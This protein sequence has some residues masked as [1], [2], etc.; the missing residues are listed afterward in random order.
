[1][2]WIYLSPHFDDIA[3]SCGGLVWEQ[4]QSGEMV[5]IWTIC[6]GSPATQPLSGF[7]KSLHSRWE[8]DEGAMT[9]RREEDKRAN[10]RL[11]AVTTHLSILDAIYRHSAIDGTPL[12][13]SDAELFG[14]FRAEDSGLVVEL[15]ADLRKSLPEDCELV[16]P[17]ALG[18]HVDHQLVK[19]AAQSLDQRTW[20]YADFPY[21]L[22]F[23]GAKEGFATGMKQ[24]IFPV[25]EAGLKIWGE[26]AAEHRS[27][28][29]TFWSDIIEMQ[30]A[31]HQHWAK[32]NGVILWRQT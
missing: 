11:G 5:S 3:L 18:G 24:K 13:T 20:Y 30:K 25:S 8:A 15:H 31:I 1:M 21:V 9:V 10:Q 14:E 27:Q 12:Y 4:T 22:Q 6:A 17:L 29:S 16:C 2:H 28:I 26:A 23:E 32:V 7:A 19:L